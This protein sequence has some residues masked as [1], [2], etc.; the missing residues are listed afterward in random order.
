MVAGERNSEV[1]LQKEMFRLGTNNLPICRHDI[2]K[3][4]LN[5]MFT[6][7]LRQG[8]GE[9]QWPGTR[10]QP[11]LPI[12]RHYCQMAEPKNY[13]LYADYRPTTRYNSI[14]NHII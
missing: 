11:D 14:T 1:R 2:L 6:H 10:V 12:R 7:T 9:T 4:W 8:S 3:R 13:L 5:C